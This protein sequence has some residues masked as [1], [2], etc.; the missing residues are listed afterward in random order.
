MSDQTWMVVVWLLVLAGLTALLA[1]EANEAFV[2]RWTS[3]KWTNRSRRATWWLGCALLA[4]AGG[5][6]IWV[7][8]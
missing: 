1:S 8:A 7:L 3:K 5:L 2:R 6:G 4:V